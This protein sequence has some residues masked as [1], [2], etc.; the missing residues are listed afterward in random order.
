LN[1]LNISLFFRAMIF[2]YLHAHRRP[3]GWAIWFTGWC[4]GNDAYNSNHNKQQTTW[5]AREQS[6]LVKIKEVLNKMMK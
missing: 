1:E 5:I 2:I 3:R 4:A 6:E